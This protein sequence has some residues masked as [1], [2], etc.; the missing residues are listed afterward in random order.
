M[1]HTDPLAAEV[2]PKGRKPQPDGMVEKRGRALGIYASGT[3]AGAAFGWLAGG[4]LFYLLDGNW[5][6]VLVAVGLPGV[7]LALLVATTVREPTR[8]RAEATASDLAALPFGH[9]ILGHLRPLS[10]EKLF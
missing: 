2:P 3:Q 1:A 8:G 5:R 4:W 10:K 7:L 6:L 9:P